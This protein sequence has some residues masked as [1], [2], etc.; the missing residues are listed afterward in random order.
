MTAYIA[1]DAQSLLEEHG[2]ADFEA[3]WTLPLDAVD[4]P[5]TGRGGSSS[6]YRLELGTAAFY[7]KRQRNYL[8]RSLCHP[9]GE[10]TFAREFRN[11]QRYRRKGI[12]AL[13]AAYFA[14][15]KVAG[16]SQA[17]L[18]TRALDGWQDLEV[19]LARWREL[20]PA[21]RRGIVGAC[22]RLAGTLHGAG[23]KHGCFY[24]KH[25]FLR[26][27]AEGFEACLI[28]LEKT[29]MLLPGRGDRIRDLETLVRRARPWSSVE[30]R[31]LFAAYL[32]L[33]AADPRIDGW[34]A[35]LSGRRRSKEGRA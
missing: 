18:L 14:Q 23:Q 15:R 16:E 12:P 10:P 24:P 25:I 13:E 1:S 9:W 30:L 33:D 31:E 5:N 27:G 28:D 2:L 17:M 20:E 34:L 21:A 26:E 4:E 35:R 22:G 29:R 6:V 7:L 8:T 32:Q 11:I 19:W 3:L